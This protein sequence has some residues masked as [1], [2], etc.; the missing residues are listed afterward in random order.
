[1]LKLKD[2]SEK[3]DLD[4]KSHTSRN[5]DINIEMSTTKNNSVQNRG[6]NFRRTNSMDP[7][8]VQGLK[9]IHETF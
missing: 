7:S 4:L 3:R 6:A 2:D 9:G 8:L 1:M 5:S